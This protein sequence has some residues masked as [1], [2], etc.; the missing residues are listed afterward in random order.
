MILAG[1]VPRQQQET[2]LSWAHTCAHTNRH[3]VGAWKHL[4]YPRKHRELLLVIESLSRATTA[5]CVALLCYAGAGGWR[6]SWGLWCPASFHRLLPCPRI[7]TL[8]WPGSFWAW[9]HVGWV[10][11]A[12][13]G[14]CPWVSALSATS[15]LM[16]G[17]HWGGRVFRDHRGNEDPQGW[18]ALAII[19]ASPS[20]PGILSLGKVLPC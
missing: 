3:M 10:L 12:A 20:I 6:C 9:L 15:W 19:M 1:V 8:P 18:A 5:A 2:G 14:Q 17:G 16:P 11:F 13:A 7:H 4:L